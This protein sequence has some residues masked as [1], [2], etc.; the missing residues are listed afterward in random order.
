MKIQGAWKIT[1]VEDSRRTQDCI[2]K[3]GTIHMIDSLVNEWH[4]A[5]AIA[6]EKTFFGIMAEDAIYIGTDPG[7]R[8]TKNEL[9]EWSLAYFERKSAWAF[10]PMSRNIKIASGG[11]L[12]WFDELL[13]TNMGTCRSTGI[14]M[15]QDDIWKIVHYQLSVAVPNDKLDKIKKLIGEK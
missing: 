14:L 1:Q 8:W 5:A 4:H 2:D 10:R 6:D 3:A 13:D 12:A 9:K 7:E 11:Q 15:K